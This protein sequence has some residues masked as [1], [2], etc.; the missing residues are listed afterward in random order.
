MKAFIFDLDG[1]IVNTTYYHYLAWRAL[2]HDLGF[3]FNQEQNEQLKGVS[4]MQSLELVLAA[5]RITNLTMK[6][7]ENL[8]DKKNHY[9][10][11]MISN[12]GEDEI[13]PGIPEFLKKI[14]IKGY[15]AALGSASRSAKFILE[16]VR[17]D[18]CFDAVVDGSMAVRAK[19]DPDIFRK[20]ADLLQIPYQNCIVVED[21]AA[22]IE[23]AKNA[24][25]KSIGIGDENILSRADFILSETK[26]LLELDLE[27]L[28]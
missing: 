19:P 22:G 17:L 26:Q 4:R 6:E 8:A 15:A 5:G 25:M 11:Q 16:R 24:G 14:K 18:S 28:L 10:R 3:E 13:L 21:A 7:K 9:Y 1:V 20:A 12:L 23:A 2:A 27:K